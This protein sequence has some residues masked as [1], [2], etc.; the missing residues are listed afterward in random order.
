[1]EGTAQCEEHRLPADGL[2]SM[3]SSVDLGGPY[4]SVV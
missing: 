2:G 3:P 1:M 4:T